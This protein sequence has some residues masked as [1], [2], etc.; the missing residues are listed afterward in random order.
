MMCFLFLALASLTAS[1]NVVQNNWQNEDQKIDFG[2]KLF[3]D[4]ANYG[5]KKSNMGEWLSNLKMYIDSFEVSLA[6]MKE[7]H[8]S[9]IYL[10]SLEATPVL[11][12]N[13]KGL[14]ISVSL[15]NVFIEIGDLVAMGFMEIGA[16]NMTVTNMTLNLFIEVVE[17]NYGLIQS[18]QIPKDNI[19]VTTDDISTTLLPFY[20]IFIKPM[21]PSMIS[22]VIDE[23]LNP[24]LTT[25]F[26]NLNNHAAAYFM[27]EYVDN[28]TL[29]SFHDDISDLTKSTIIDALSFILNKF[30]SPDGILSINSVIDR[31]LSG[32]QSIRLSTLLPLFGV[33][34]PLSLLIAPEG[35]GNISLSLYDLA[36][37]GLNTFA[38]FDFLHSVNEYTFNNSMSLDNLDLNLSFGFSILADS[39]NFSSNGIT[40]T[41]NDDINISLENNQVSIQMQAITKEGSSDHYTDAQCMNADCIGAMFSENGTQLNSFMLNT[42]IKKFDIESADLNGEED[43]DMIEHSIYTFAS[44]TLNYVLSEYKNAI[45]LYA[46]SYAV[47]A[48]N[49]QINNTLS[50]LECQYLPDE[51]Y[52]D[53][54]LWTTMT[55]IGIA[56]ALVIV[57][58]VL[59]SIASMKW[60][61]HQCE[62][63]TTSHSSENEGEQ[64]QKEGEK[65]VQEKEEGVKEL[66]YFLAFFRCDNK[67]SLLMNEKLPLVVRLLIPLLIFLNVALFVSSNT[68]LGASV[69]IKF[70]VGPDKIISLPSMFDFGLINTISDTWKAGSYGLSIIVAVFSCIWPYTKLIMMICIWILPTTILSARR[71]ETFLKVLDALGK[72]SLVDSFVMV[73]MII[74]FHF[75][76][77]LPVQNPEVEE[78]FAVNLF[79]YPA[80]G[81]V[82]L[83]VGTI[84][85]LAISHI[86]LALDRYVD[87]ALDESQQT[88]HKFRPLFTFCKHTFLKYFVTIVIVATLITLICGLVLKTFSF[89]FVGLIGWAMTLLGVDHKKEYSVIDLAYD[90]PPS[91][92]NPNSA[93]IRFTQ[94]LFFLIS[95]V[96]PIVHVV[97]LLILWVVPLT[98]KI[99]IAI[100]KACEVLYAWACLDVFVVSILVSLAEISQFARFLVGDKCVEIDEIIRRFF[101]QE[102]LIEGHETCF[103][104]ITVMMSGSWLLFVAAIMHNVAT[105]I[106]NIVARK[107]LAE[108]D[109]SSDGMEA[110]NDE[111]KAQED[112]TNQNA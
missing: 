2:K 40:L 85:S 106:V 35:F 49:N 71:R 63:S 105:V 77:S 1:A 111:E 92:E 83:A 67:S 101:S 41:Q 25:L 15:S 43:K 69:F 8:L 93:S 75:H 33:N 7:V 45:F 80:Y 86:M 81:F 79:V 58:G 48:V 53:F 51:P 36:I 27:N 13:R 5:Q 47:P 110:N 102:Y 54:T 109:Q 23:N 95:I 108:M 16:C 89:D 112:N 78:P 52:S 104:V 70:V 10:N 44:T 42:T 56:L 65:N 21:F 103:D 66:G 38:D 88:S 9:E 97:L 74:A 99:Q 17:N 60:N 96:L 46:I 3:A 6:T 31:L 84:V 24:L 100:F 64:E 4:D 14:E 28:G 55:A 73:L 59:A 61:T 32:A 68:G 76:I 62:T 22:E 19:E 107:T 87:D 30:I 90:L 98:K 18:V 39:P 82:T 94:V 12:E 50:A 34:G 57:V 37:S 29:E 91:A 20:E 72:W 26:D 11:E